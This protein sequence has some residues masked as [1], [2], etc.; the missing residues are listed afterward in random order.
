MSENTKRQK[1]QRVPR[2][3][4]TKLVITLDDAGQPV[5]QFREITRGEMKL[6]PVTENK[7]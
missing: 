1:P 2:I 5:E 7:E 4:K 3:S 6:I